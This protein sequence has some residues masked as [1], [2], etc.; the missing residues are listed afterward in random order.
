MVTLNSP[1]SLERQ[2]QYDAV[3][4]LSLFSVLCVTRRLLSLRQIE[5]LG[6]TVPSVMAEG[7]D[8]ETISSFYDCQV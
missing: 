5:F 8:T 4:T 6:T 1:Y 7:Q 3:N 2:S